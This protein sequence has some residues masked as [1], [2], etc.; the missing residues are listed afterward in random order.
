MRER[1]KPWTRA[2][3]GGDFKICSFSLGIY[4]GFCLE[5]IHH[6]HRCEQQGAQQHLEVRSP[7]PLAHP[8]FPF[9]DPRWAEEPLASHPLSSGEVSESTI[10]TGNGGRAPLPQPLRPTAG[11]I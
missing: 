10:G 7:S 4:R 5:V 11:E 3:V 2:S 9:P 8:R 6:K 1:K